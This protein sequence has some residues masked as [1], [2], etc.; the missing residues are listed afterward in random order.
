MVA[1]S[2]LD[3]PPAEAVKL[4]PSVDDEETAIDNGFATGVRL[5]ADIL[6]RK[7]QGEAMIAVTRKYRELVATRLADL[8][9]EARVP[10]Y[11][12]NPDLHT[13]GH[14]KY[15][16]LMMERAGARNVAAAL[17]GF[18][19]VGMED[20]LQWDPAV[21]FVQNRYPA[22]VDEIRDS[23]AWQTVSAVRSD[24]IYFMPE[25]A[26]AWGYPMPE[27]L[28]LGELWMAKQLYPERFEDIDMQEEADAYYRQFYRTDYHAAE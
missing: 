12:A 7:A 4:N 18:Q 13:Y 14:G 11:M 26:K 1:I 21:I 3:V 8:T 2:L 20:V 28:S 15:T 25:Y 5:I 16:G 10:V 27:A 24:R 23:A 17:T 6:N 19:Q 22:V 9:D